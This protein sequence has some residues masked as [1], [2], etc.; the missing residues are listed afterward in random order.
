MEKFERMKH[1]KSVLPPDKKWQLIWSDEFDGDILDLTKWSYRL[2][3]L[4][5]RH[6][7][8]TN[9]G[10]FLDGKGNLLLTLQ[11]KDGQFYSPHLQTGSNY[12]DI[13][14][15][16]FCLDEAKKPKFIWPVGKL[17]KPKFMHK[18]GYYEIRCK[19]PEQPGWWAAFWLQSPCIGS[20]L[21]PAVS[22]VEVDIM[23]NFSRDGIVFHNN[24]WNG[25]GPDHETTGSGER[26]LDETPDG[27]HVFGLEW[28]PSEY[29][30]YIDGKESWRCRGPISHREQFIL[31]STECFGY[32]TGNMPDPSLK[33][34]ILPDYF[35]IDYVRVFDEIKT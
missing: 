16:A 3:L 29:I 6:E 21:D 15:T 10:A 23:E 35:I 9:Q 4:Q 12:L 33:K 27:F 30:Y 20:T 19:L 24:H 8:F 31:L 28:T 26:K 2:H 32:R 11:E 5:K 1:I 18:Y 34:A 7:T 17:E 13:P 25:Y 14:G 22:G